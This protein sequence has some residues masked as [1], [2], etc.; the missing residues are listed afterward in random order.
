MAAHGSSHLNLT[1]RCNNPEGCHLS[2]TCLESLC[3]RLYIVIREERLVFWEVL[4]S[5]FVKNSLQELVSYSEYL[6]R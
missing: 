4:V 6:P 2:N 3:G 1:M 5:V